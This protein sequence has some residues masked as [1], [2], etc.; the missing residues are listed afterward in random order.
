MGAEWQKE[1]SEAAWKGIHEGAVLAMQARI[2][3]LEKA[4]LKA[5]CIK[6]DDMARIEQLEG[7]L[8]DLV[9]ACELAGDHCEVEEAMMLARKALE[10]KNAHS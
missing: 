4:N 3:Q 8:E 6:V 1:R 10:E 7:A 2:D 5:S 9:M